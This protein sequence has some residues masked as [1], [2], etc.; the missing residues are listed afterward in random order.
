MSA[1]QVWVTWSRMHHYHQPG[2]LRQLSGSGDLAFMRPIEQDIGRTLSDHG[3]FSSPSASG[4]AP[5]RRILRSYR[6][7]VTMPLM[8]TDLFF[9]S[10]LS[11]SATHRLATA[12]ACH[13]SRDACC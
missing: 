6:C 4:I 1:W 8:A 10:V 9:L 2:V 7:A 5:L 12:R 3:M 11:A 13:C